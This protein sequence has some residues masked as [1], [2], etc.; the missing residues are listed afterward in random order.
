MSE[1]QAWESH[2]KN[3]K[4]NNVGSLMS[5]YRKQIRA[6]CV[7]SFF[8]RFFPK[9]GLFVECGSGSSETSSRIRG[10]RHLVSLDFALEP[11]CIAR[12]IKTVRSCVNGDILALPFKRNSVDGIW[13]LG[14]MEH[15][16][17]DNQV[18]VLKEF[19]RVLK[20]GAKV[21]LWWPPKIALDH[22]ILS[23]FGNF[24]PDE[25][26]RVTKREAKEIMMSAG[27]VDVKTYFPLSDAFTE[28][29]VVGTKG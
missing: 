21:V 17:R 1:Q 29:V 4:G 18:K 2:W 10:N 26:G 11:L 28:L 20:P 24:F 19:L 16:V 9:E 14:V 22:A 8:E 27:F 7:A 15:F 6:R 25:P 23:L 12:N 5:I 3:L 13:N